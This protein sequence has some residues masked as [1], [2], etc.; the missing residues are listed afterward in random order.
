MSAGT[1][2]LTRPL[3]VL[4]ADQQEAIVERLARE[5]LALEDFHVRTLPPAQTSDAI[6]AS[7]RA[8]GRDLEEGTHHQ[9][10]QHVA[11]LAQARTSGGVGS[12]DAR[13]MCDSVARALRDACRQLA[14]PAMQVE[15]LEQVGLIMESVWATVFENYVEG[16]TAA[17]EDAYRAV[18]RELS[19][20]IIPIHAGVLVLPLIGPIDAARGEMLAA[21]LMTAISRVHATGVLLDVT[22]VPAIDASV[23][24]WLV[25][26]TRSARL[27]GAE[28]V[29]V[30]VSS[31]IAVTMADARLDLRGLQTFGTLQAGFEHVLAR[32]GL[33][34]GPT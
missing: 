27:L 14:E 13:S 32:R 12:R 18:L 21:M 24:A 2:G 31:A 26:L 23:A 1:T 33:R 20:P 19:V 5:V 30:G 11:T 34:I 6:R 3:A 7:L 17:V 28:L 25:R 10:A 16:M 4:I 15:A 29:L 9:Y 8:I 22:G